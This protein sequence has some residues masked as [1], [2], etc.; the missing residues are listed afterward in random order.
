MFVNGEE[1]IFGV[2]LHNGG[3]KREGHQHHY[4]Y[5]LIVFSYVHTILQIL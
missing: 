4:V 5:T 1:R 3:K 2:Q